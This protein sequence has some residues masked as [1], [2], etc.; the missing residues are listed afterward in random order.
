MS[1]NGKRYHSEYEKKGFYDVAEITENIQQIINFPFMMDSNCIQI[2]V[3]DVQIFALRV[4]NKKLLY[5]FT[6]LKEVTFWS[7]S[8]DPDPTVL[9]LKPIKLEIT[10]RVV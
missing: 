3:I 4:R 10:G 2:K 1:R 7:N 9:S 8:T 6:E 5:R